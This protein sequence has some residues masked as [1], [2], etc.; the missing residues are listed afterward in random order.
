L[1]RTWVGTLVST[2]TDYFFPIN[3][4]AKANETSL[5]GNKSMKLKLLVATTKTQGQRKND[6]CHATEGEILRVGMQCDRE[7]VDGQC[8]CR[9]C[10]VGLQSGKGTTTF[11]AV[12]KEITAAQLLEMVRQS[13]QETGWL[14]FMCEADVHEE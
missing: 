12:E 10:L 14:K 5:A 9:R 3:R 8:G 7:R 4:M 1:L 6:F 2:E 13:L 11:M